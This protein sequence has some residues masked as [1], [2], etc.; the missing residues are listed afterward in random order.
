MKMKKDKFIENEFCTYFEGVTP[1]P[2]VTNDAKRLIPEQ[3]SRRK[4]AIGFTSFASAFASVILV[5]AI[6]LLMINQNKITYYSTSTVQVKALSYNEITDESLESA[7]E[8]FEII[9]YSSN[10]HA[11]YY[12]YYDDKDNLKFIEI[13][14]TCLNNYGREDVKIYIEVTGK[15]VTCEDFKA[16]YELEDEE[17]INGVSYKYESESLG[18]EWVSK[19]YFK[20]NN[21]KYFV[22]TQVPTVKVDKN[23]TLEKYLNLLI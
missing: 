21:L 13:R 11:D 17:E 18:G 10:A 9:E 23:F 20:N 5:I 19:A 6:A 7:M 1:P 22:E 8:P 16:F 2:G 3:K 15:K 14:I 4:L 12:L